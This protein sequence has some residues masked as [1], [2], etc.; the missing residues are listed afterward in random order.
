MA[1]LI[2]KQKIIFALSA[3]R[4][5]WRFSGD[6]ILYLIGFHMCKKLIHGVKM[7]IC[8]ET[9]V[10]YNHIILNFYFS[11]ILSESK[12]IEIF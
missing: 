12:N 3:Q 4:A 7:V 11:A 2:S 6:F 1:Y 10:S 8:V 5:V 9:N